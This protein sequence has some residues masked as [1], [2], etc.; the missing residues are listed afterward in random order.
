MSSE[1]PSARAAS[2]G[3]PGVTRAGLVPP[4]RR[5]FRT[6]WIATAVAVLAGLVTRPVGADAPGVPAQVQAELLAKLASYDRNFGDR[7]GAKARVLLVVKSGDAKSK[8]FGASLKGA[9]DNVAQIGGLPHEELQVTYEGGAQL[10]ARCRAAKAA[11]VYVMPGLEGEVD[12]IR[13]ALKGVDVLSVSAVPENVPD[14]IVI[15]FE[16]VSGKPKI[17]VNL[18]Q[19][20]EQNVNFKADVLKLMKV[21]R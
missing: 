16:L 8:Y 17:L 10:A 1:D 11:V 2:P 15:G 14:G 7:A 4:G 6:R 5:A 18:P 12:S 21:Y 9:L 13:T 3:D 19:A 20:R